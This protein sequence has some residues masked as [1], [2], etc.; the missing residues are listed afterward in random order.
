MWQGV[1]STNNLDGVFR[2]LNDE[3]NYIGLYEYWNSIEAYIIKY[4]NTTTI[5]KIRMFD[6]IQ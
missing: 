3:I 2:A 5:L 6:D 1:N 4:Y